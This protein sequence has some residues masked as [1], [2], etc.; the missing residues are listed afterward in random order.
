[1]LRLRNRLVEGVGRLAYFTITDRADVLEAI[2]AAKL[3]GDTRLAAAVKGAFLPYLDTYFAGFS[4]T[5]PRGSGERSFMFRLWKDDPRFLACFAH[6]VPLGV[7]HSWKAR[8]RG[9]PAVEVVRDVAG[10]R[11]VLV[12]DVVTTGRT[13]VAHLLPLL[14]GGALA[15]GLVLRE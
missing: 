2:K 10:R 8:L 7:S 15:T 3:G 11:V 13:L 9:Y 4:I 12:D 6:D 5:T 14:R 1:M